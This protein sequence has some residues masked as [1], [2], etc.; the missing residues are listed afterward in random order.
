MPDQGER[1]GDPACGEHLCEV[2]GELLDAIPAHRRLTRSAVPAVVVANDPDGAAVPSQQVI[3]LAHRRRLAQTKPV[4]ENNGLTGVSRAAVAH[5]K[6]HTVAHRHINV[7]LAPAALDGAATSWPMIADGCG[8][9]IQS[10][11]SAARPPY[12]IA[13][14]GHGITGSVAGEVGMDIVDAALPM[15][16]GHGH[17]PARRRV[18]RLISA[19]IRRTA[20]Q[21]AVADGLGTGVVGRFGGIE[22]D[23]RSFAAP[24]RK[25]ARQLTLVTYSRTGRSAPVVGAGS[26]LRWSGT[27]EAFLVPF[28]G[29]FGRIQGNPGAADGLADGIAAHQGSA[30]MLRALA[31]CPWRRQ[32][33]SGSSDDPSE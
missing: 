15:N 22:H 3:G 21:E 25:F 5:G 12:L 31:D 26:G 20:L 30:V 33:S 18:A 6:S 28:R 9:V 2:I 4:Q 24:P 14:R 11:G 7:V 19:P 1:P 29:P 8:L 23:R 27:S 16:P 13:G 32:G 17:C 10:G